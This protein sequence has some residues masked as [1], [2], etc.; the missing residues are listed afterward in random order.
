MTVSQMLAAWR[1]AYAPR[2]GSPL[3]GAGDPADG[4]GNPIGAIG[5]GTQAGDGF[6]TFGR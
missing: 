2:A 6:G 1:A 5:D 4:R 3:A